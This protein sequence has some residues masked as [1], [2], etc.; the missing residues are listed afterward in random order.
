MKKQ[1]EHGLTRNQIV[2]ELVKSS[3]GNL[4]AY[5]SVGQVAAREHAEFLAHLIAWNQIKGQVRDSKTALPVVS[6]SVPEFNDA[7]FVE[8]SLAHIA[9][10]DPRNL[11]RAWRM[12]KKLKVPGHMMQ[13]RRLTEAYL[14]N[15]EKNWIKYETNS[16]LHQ[17]SLRELY[18]LNHTKPSQ[19]ADNA[20]IKRKDYVPGS[21]FEAVAKLPLM[22]ATEAA[23]VI[24]TKKLPFLVVAGALQERIKEPDIAL[25]ML[26]RMSAT[27]LVT[28]GKMLEKFGVKSDPAI[29]AAFEKALE[30]AS[31]SS[32]NVLKTTQAV[33]NLEDEGLKEKF[34]VL[35]EKQI[36]KMGGIEGNWLVLGDKSGSMHAAIEATRVVAATLAKMVKGDVWLI[37]FDTHPTYYK[38]TGKA[39]D[40]I[41]TET[42]RVQANGGTSIGCGLR[43]AM[44]AKLD[45][46]GI[47]VI[48]D[49]GENTA[50]M[51]GAEYKKY[52]EAFDREPTVYA[53]LT[54]GDGDAFSG[55]C[56]RD[57]IDL[58]KF[59]LKAMNWDYYS[60]PNVVQT[61]RVSRYSLMDEILGVPLIKL[62]E[63]FDGAEEVLTKTAATSLHG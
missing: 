60:L 55:N 12:A 38:V 1:I 8:N 14:R 4:D 23:G 43:Y 30:K 19:I 49:G 53:Y 54:E 3:H 21:K 42:R 58:Q 27:E 39:Y 16:V 11:V 52:C 41:L 47:A 28:N 62:E 17:N 10:L 31:K 24:L 32:K 6:L 15:R 9:M 29:R 7:E 25:A 50:P 2:N 44:D 36:E 40:E 46:D 56:Q 18:G 22:S 26:D 57:G 51:F 59:N 33:E 61:M 35:Q 13:I 34:R 45:V 37:Y 63:V 5:T 20:L 48:T